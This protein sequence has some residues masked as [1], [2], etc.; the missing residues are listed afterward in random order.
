[1]R[2]PQLTRRRLFGG[3]AAGLAAS[4]LPLPGRAVRAESSL[5]PLPPPLPK[6]AFRER[7]EKVREQMARRRIDA[8]FVTP[9]TNLRYLANLSI[10]RSE[11]LTAL[12]LPAKGPAVVVTPFFERPRSEKT[13]VF[14]R[15]ETWQ[16]SEDPFAL[17]GKVLG[18]GRTVA[19]EGST[20]LHAAERLRA[21]AGAALRDG[22]DLLDALR[23]IKSPAEQGFIRAAGIRTVAAIEATWARL[24]AGMTELQGAEI[25]SE[26][27]VRAGVPSDG[28]VQF[29]PSSALP[30]GGPGGRP[31]A[32][33]DVVLIDC[34]CLVEGY[35]SDITRTA[36]FGKP[37][38]RVRRVY[39][40]V[41]RAQRA[42][43]DA[44]A[45]GVPG[46]KVDAAARKVITD[47]GFGEF[48]THRLGHGL[49][50]DGHES[51]Y[52]VSGNGRPL[53]AGNVE[54]VEPGIYLPGEFGVRIEDD[55][56]VTAGGR[57]RLSPPPAGLRI[58]A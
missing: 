9:S 16:E 23:E 58:L 42:G 40:V 57:D 53:A 30:H 48:F 19:V 17:C 46:E 55:F 39:D 41:E 37:S 31:L 20:A 11:R 56:A 28:L 49:G 33:G 52:L 24:R 10:G 4:A 44:L 50:M 18:T 22:T 51:P 32:A 13:G 12:L 5:P 43:I 7:Q 27:F 47:A 29:G 25:L 26:E 14:D 45:A 36:C 34:G 21:A 1:M 3:M 8:L 2:S 35:T 6:E 15:I 54:T 38:D